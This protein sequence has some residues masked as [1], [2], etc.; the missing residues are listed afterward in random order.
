[1][2]GINNLKCLASHSTQYYDV[3]RTQVLTL[4]IYPRLMTNKHVVHPLFLH[5][6]SKQGHLVQ[7]SWA[8]L[9]ACAW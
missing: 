9:R 4:S 2:T 6:R 8:N 7:F 3:Y 1:M 5:D